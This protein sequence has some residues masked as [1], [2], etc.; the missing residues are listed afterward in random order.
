ML[1]VQLIIRTPNQP[2]VYQMNRS[3]AKSAKRMQMPK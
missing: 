1:T 2:T 3:I